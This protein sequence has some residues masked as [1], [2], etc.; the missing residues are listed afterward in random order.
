MQQFQQRM[1]VIGNNIANINTTGF[2]AGRVEL[3]ESFS[4]TLK[5]ASAGSASSGSQAGSQIGTGVAT[6]TI[7][8][9]FKQG[10]IGASDMAT[11]L[12]VQGDGFFVVKNVSDGNM[13][14]TRDGSFRL[15]DQ[16]YLVT[17]AGMRVQ[18]FS[19]S[20]L[21]TRGDIKIDDVGKPSSSSP[22]AKVKSFLIGDDGRIN[23]KLSDDTQFDRGQVLMQ[24]FNDPQALTK[25]GGNLY[26]GIAGAGPLG[27]AAS[28]TSAVPNTNGLGV[29]K[30]GA[31]ELSNVNVEAERVNLFLAERAYETTSKAM[32][33]AEKILQ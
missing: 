4:Q 27:G 12:A 26:S 22:S 33:V 13:F 28:P 29:I 21:S 6:A 10:A 32:Q 25:Q 11:D 8:N 14:A 16:G 15:D 24:K 9:L 23:V 5:G 31:L 17:D 3:A 7:R 30:S 1:D 18:G 20:G 19:D 2:K